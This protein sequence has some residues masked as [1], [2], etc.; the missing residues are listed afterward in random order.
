ML[1]RIHWL[2]TTPQPLWNAQR[3][4]LIEQQALSQP[5]HPSLMERAGLAIA[6]LACAMAP[7]ARQ[8][9]VLC[10]PG[11]NGG[12]GLVAARHL[13][14]R[15]LTVW[16]HWLGTP[17]ACSADSNS[18]WQ[19]LKPYPVHWLTPEIIP[20]LQADDIVIDALLGLGQQ[21]RP[22]SS[23]S[24]LQTLLQHSYA[25]PAHALAV[26]VPTGLDTNSGAWLPGFT[27]PAHW[28]PSSRH[29][30]SLLT[31]KPG[32]FTHHGRDACG[33]IWWDDLACSD[34]LQQHPPTAWLNATPT[35]IQRHHNSHKGSFG[36]VLVIG[37]AS[38]MAGAAILAATAALHHGA[39]RTLLHLL[40]PNTSCHHTIAPD[41]MQPDASSTRA[42]L[43]SATVVC[44]CCGGSAIHAWL[45]EVLQQTPQLVLDA[46]ALN[47]IAQDAS[48]ATALQARR[49]RGQ[50]TILTPHPLE[51]ARLLQQSTAD[52]Q[53]HR[54]QAAQ[55]LAERLQCT[56]VLKGSG[57]IIAS[58][59]QT[60]HINP[61]GNARL[62]IG[63]TGDVLAGMVAARW[64]QQPS[65]HL[66]ACEAVWE[67]GALAE[68]WPSTQP[69]TASAL[70]CTP[71]QVI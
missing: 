65:T 50:A 48:L 39:G 36:D 58:P 23:N 54:L 17:D 13:V 11:N 47:A 64:Q 51:A 61:T 29:T 52:I 10:G 37:G 12:D 28:Q 9:W 42:L 16:V 55:T 15:G 3:S 45:P 62:A 7:H 25:S 8:A 33:Q 66:A 38:S 6:Q 35:H 1:Q 2:N 41:L 46:D 31:L 22:G 49:A 67:H 27:P 32:L 43:G 19:Q 40:A 59:A 63:G 44:G 20:T 4:K 57:S 71:W 18:A 56:V 30:L 34:T 5:Q 60:P 14:Q 24:S 69:L 68:N 26:D 21:A 70:A 53:A